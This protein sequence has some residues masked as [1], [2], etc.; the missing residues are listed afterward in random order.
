MKLYSIM[1]MRVTPKSE[2]EP[3]ILSSAVDVSNVGIWQRSSAREFLIF[4]SRTVAKRMQPMSRTQVNE[5]EH[6]LFAQSFANGSLVATAVA[7]SEYNARV[8]FSMLA[9]VST[10]FAE[11]FRGQWEGATRDNA[12]TWAF[13]DATLVKY[14]NPAEADQIMKIQKDIEDTKIIMHNAIDSVLER[15]EKIDHLVDLSADLGVA[16]KSFYK[17]AKKTNSGCCVVC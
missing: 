11:Q 15:G 13:I 14:Q 6:V 17:G 9:N 2:T 10:Q 1:V 4:L 5:K 16:S 12:L 3:L 7:D 8:A